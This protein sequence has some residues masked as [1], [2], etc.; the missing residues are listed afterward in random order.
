[1]VALANGMV[2]IF[3]RDSNGEWDLSRYRLV[4]L[5][6]PQHSVR[7][8]TVVGDKV[9][10]GYRNK[11]HVLDPTNAKILHSFEAHPRRES[12]VSPIICR[13]VRYKLCILKV[14][15]LAWL[16]EGV[17]VSIRLDSTLRL[18]HAHT[19]DHLQDVDIEP[20]V[21]KMLGK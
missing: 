1:M 9:W 20:Y 16:G 4:Q 8:L 14:R 21:S 18:Y 11:I 3:R 12:E 10:L 2:A 13:D 19:Y 6:Q 15:Q 7:T 5:G 17:W